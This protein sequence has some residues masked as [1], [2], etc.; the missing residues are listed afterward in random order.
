MRYKKIVNGFDVLFFSII[1]LT[2]IGFSNNANAFFHDQDSQQDGVIDDS[3]KIIESLFD[4]VNMAS[5][6]YQSEI[7]F[8]N[9]SIN[10]NKTMINTT[11]GYI[12]NLKKIILFAKKTTVQQNYKPV[13][14]NYIDSIENEIESYVHYKEYIITGNLTENKISMDLLSKAYN[15]E[16]QAINLYKQLELQ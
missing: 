4:R 16:T 2:S 12:D 13:L 5:N 8:L 7:S 3:K 11:Q 1:V 15:Y 14:N 10:D 6:N 9:Q